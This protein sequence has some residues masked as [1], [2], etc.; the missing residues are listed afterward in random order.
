M[1]LKLHSILEDEPS[2]EI[3]NGYIYM[4]IK[5]IYLNQIRDNKEFVF[6]NYVFEAVEDNDT[7]TKREMVAD[8]MD[9]LGFF[10]K[11]ILYKCSEISIRDLAE[12]IG[13][14]KGVIQHHKA[15]AMN[16]IKEIANGT[17]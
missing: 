4:M 16:L 6:D 10:H 14:S 1:Y 8:L 9:N 11:E 15:V 2:K 3:T 5:S 12:E 13:C 17:T 7:L